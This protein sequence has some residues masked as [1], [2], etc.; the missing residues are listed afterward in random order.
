MPFILYNPTITKHEP[1]P[2]V[3]PMLHIVHPN[4]FANCNNMNTTPQHLHN[5]P[6]TPPLLIPSSLNESIDNDLL[7]TTDIND[8]GSAS[9][10]SING[11]TELVCDNGPIPLTCDRG[12]NKK[13][14]S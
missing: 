11:N 5:A 8:D 14:F 1:T 4:Y 3:A 12:S 2:M 13:L 6:P 9:D 7:T 10:S